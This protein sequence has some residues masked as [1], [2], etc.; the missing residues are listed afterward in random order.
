MNLP[1][2]DI[3]FIVDFIL[4]KFVLLKNTIDNQ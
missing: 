1:N 3:R 2:C 4:K